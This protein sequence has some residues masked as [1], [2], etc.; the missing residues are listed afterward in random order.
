[1]RNSKATY[2]LLDTTKI[3][4][5]GWKPMYKVSDALFETFKIKK[6]IV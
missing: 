3:K 6:S 1:M 2:A 4:C 5:L